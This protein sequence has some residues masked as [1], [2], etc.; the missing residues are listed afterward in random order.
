MFGFRDRSLVVRDLE[1]FR[2]KICLGVFD[3]KVEECRQGLLKICQ[4]SR[5]NLFSL[6]K[7]FEVKEDV[8]Q[9]GGGWGSMVGGVFYMRGIVDS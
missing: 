6:W 2:N 9:K 1:L 4:F 7:L 5:F 3:E 8:F